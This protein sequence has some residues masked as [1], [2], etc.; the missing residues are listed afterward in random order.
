MT[1]TLLVYVSCL[2][3]ICI[4]GGFL[5]AH[6]RRDIAECERSG[7]LWEPT[8]PFLV[9]RADAQYICSRCFKEL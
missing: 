5:H 8:N 2:A 1:T 9:D 7:H 4:V 6:H 3:I